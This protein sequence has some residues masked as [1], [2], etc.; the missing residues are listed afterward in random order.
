MGY[1][2]VSGVSCVLP[3]GRTLFRDVSFRVGEGAKVALIGANGTG[4]TTLM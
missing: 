4:K 2:D 1:V 3:D